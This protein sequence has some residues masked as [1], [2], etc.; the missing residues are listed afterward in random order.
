[1]PAS[2]KSDDSHDVEAAV[3]LTSDGCDNLSSPHITSLDQG[4]VIP[5]EQLV[6]LITVGPKSFQT[7]RK[8]MENMLWLS[9]FS[10]VYWGIL[11]PARAQCLEIL[12][13]DPR[14]SELH[15]SS[16][17]QLAFQRL[18]ALLAR[19]KVALRVSKHGVLALLCTVRDEEGYTSI[20]PTRRTGL[21]LWES[22]F[23]TEILNQQNVPENLRVPKKVLPDDFIHRFWVE[24]EGKK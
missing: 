8:K 2:D 10:K 11:S 17:R 20:S 23:D 18:R 22:E 13:R 7:A 14:G 15:W 24:N 1:M 6:E 3:P 5:P 16:E 9:G 12:P 4:E 19:I 21:E